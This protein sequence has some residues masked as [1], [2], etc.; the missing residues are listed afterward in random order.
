MEHVAKL[1]IDSGVASPL[2]VELLYLHKQAYASLV[3][4]EDTYKAMIDRLDR[5]NASKEQRVEALLEFWNNRLGVRDVRNLPNYKPYGEYQNAFLTPGNRAGF[6]STNRFD[7]TEQDLEDEMQDYHL[8]HALQAHSEITDFFR[9]VMNGNGGMASTTEKIRA[10]IPVGGMSPSDDMGSGGA[11]Y[12]FARIVEGFRRNGL[13]FKKNLLLRHD[14]ISYANDRYGNVKNNEV[15][16]YRK[17]GI[18]DWKDIEG[19]E[20]GNETIIKN[21]FDII[22]NLDYIQVGYSGD[23]QKLI[24]IFREYGLERHPDGRT[25]NNVILVD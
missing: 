7:I 6:R 10:G 9:D 2:D 22:E 1:D 18:R 24:E 17:S 5:V 15:L 20:N 8:F 12:V 21:G 25:W 23:K 11:S 14:A 4:K 19:H 3:V 13:Y 16:H